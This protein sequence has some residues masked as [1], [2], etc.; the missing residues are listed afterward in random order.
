MLYQTIT[1]SKPIRI[2]LDFFEKNM[3]YRRIIAIDPGKSGAI[4]HID[5]NDELNPKT[6][7]RVVKMPELSRLNEYI[8][9]LV[10]ENRTLCFIE[11]VNIRPDDMQGGKAFAIQKML[12]NYNFLLAALISNNIGFIEVHPTT[13]QSYLKLRL[14]KDLAKKEDKTAR[15]NR[16]KEASQM[17]FPMIKSTLWNCDALLMLQFGWEK[18]RNDK[19][20]VYESIPNVDLDLLF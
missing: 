2:G 9:S 6:L 5:L 17:R 12:R 14:P 3:E 4:V 10:S 20:W 16:Y 11:K 18:I 1:Q 13:W 7:P 19:R 15:K 8:A